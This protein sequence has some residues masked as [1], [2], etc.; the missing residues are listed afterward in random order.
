MVL[1]VVK[2]TSVI[3][4]VLYVFDLLIDVKVLVSKNSRRLVIV[5]VTVRDWE[6]IVVSVSVDQIVIT[7]VVVVE[8]E[9][10]KKDV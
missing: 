8:G 2:F 5:L 10:V 6:A 4:L 9:L 1:V 7:S 3:V